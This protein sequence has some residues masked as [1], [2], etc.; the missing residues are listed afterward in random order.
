L[1]NKLKSL[2][3]DLKWEFPTLNSNVKKF[4]SFWFGF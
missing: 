3:E 2:Y 1:A 4:F